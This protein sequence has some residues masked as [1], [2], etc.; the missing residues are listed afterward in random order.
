MP[1]DTNSP[2][3]CAATVYFDGACPLC[4]MEIDHYRSTPG[5]DRIDF[6]DISD[7]AVAPPADLPREAALARFH[8][9]TA[10]GSLVSG[11]EAFAR[12]WLALPRWRWL[13]RFG[14][15]PVGHWILES[16]YRVVLPLRPRLA[17]WV[18]R[19]SRQ[20]ARS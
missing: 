19:L 9:R 12:L 6:V 3:A 11:A 14:L 16:G 8:A 10:D 13:G 4:R 17:G 5:S 20:P 15:T 18:R 2:D 1:Q 7:P